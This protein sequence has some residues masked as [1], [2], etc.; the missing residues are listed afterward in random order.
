MSCLL[1]Y[2]L[3][4]LCVWFSREPGAER[5]DGADG[6]PSERTSA[7]P[8]VVPRRRPGLDQRV[9]PGL[10][11]DDRGRSRGHVLLHQVSREIT[12]RRDC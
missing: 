4:P 9:H 12:S 8:D 11:A 7:V 6:V 5:G 10:P 3:L 2:A 1:F